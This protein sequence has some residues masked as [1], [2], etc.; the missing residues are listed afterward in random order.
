MPQ[1]NLSDLSE[2]RGIFIAH[3][4]EYRESRSNER[5][6][7]VQAIMEE[8]AGQTEGTLDEDTMRELDHVS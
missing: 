4:R 1:I 8:V 6:A 7:V 3:E 5:Q 2:Y